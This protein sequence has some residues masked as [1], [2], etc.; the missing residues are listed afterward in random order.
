M[1]RPVIHD[2]VG[3]GYAC[4][5]EV[6]YRHLP[7]G[8]FHV[9]VAVGQFGVEGALVVG[10]E[11]HQFRAGFL[12]RLLHDGEGVHV[13][14]VVGTAEEENIVVAVAQRV[15]DLWVGGDL[16]HGDVGIAESVHGGVFAVGCQHTLQLRRYLGRGD[17]AVAGDGDA[18]TVLIAAVQSVVPRQQLDGLQGG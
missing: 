13:L 14:A 2:Q 3:F 11:Q 16:G 12:T 7:M 9:G 8:Q 15:H 6:V 4:R 10:G 18:Q 1:V 5:D 17:E